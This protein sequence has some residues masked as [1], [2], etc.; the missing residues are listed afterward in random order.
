MCHYSRRLRSNEQRD[1]QI[2]DEAGSAQCDLSI[3]AVAG[4][5][6]GASGALST[7]VA[8]VYFMEVS[9]LPFL[10][11]SKKNGIRIMVCPSAE[12]EVRN[13]YHNKL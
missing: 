3:E 5:D 7:G 10:R 2:Q 11:F 12:I 6:T 1:L 4:E 8:V 13:A 9:S